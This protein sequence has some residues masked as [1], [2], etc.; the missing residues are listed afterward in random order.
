MLE[1]RNLPPTGTPETI[2]KHIG[3]LRPLVGWVALQ[4]DP[5]DPRLEDFAHEGLWALSTNLERRKSTDGTL[6]NQLRRFQDAA[7]NARLN[8]IAHGANSVGLAMLAADAGITYVDG[9]V[10]CPTGLEPR[11]PGPLKPVLMPM[12]YGRVGS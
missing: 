7:R 8:T 6:F 1:V 12:T 5:S 9:P 2:L 11:L 4:L 3:A 10:V